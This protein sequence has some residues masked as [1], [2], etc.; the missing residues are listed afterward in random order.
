MASVKLVVLYPPPKDVAAF[1]KLYADEHV[2]MVKKLAG[3]TKFVATKVQGS[4]QG[5]PAFHRIAE[6]HFPSL[7]ALQACAASAGG[8]E[9]LA[10]AAKISTG[11]PPVV[12]VAEEHVSTF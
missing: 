9:T 7:D 1:E 10:H 2:P 8:K 3:K 11:G 6:V 12:L 4:P 5:Q